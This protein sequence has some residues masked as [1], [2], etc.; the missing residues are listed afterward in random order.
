[1]SLY[2]LLEFIEEVSRKFEGSTWHIEYL[3]L[4][5]ELYKMSTTGSSVQSPGTNPGQKMAIANPLQ[6]DTFDPGRQPLGRWL[7][8]LEGTFR[9]FQIREEADQVAYLLH[10]VVV[11]VFGILCDQLDPVDPYT[12]SY[13]QYVNNKIKRVLRAGALEI[14]EIYIYRKRM[15]RPEESAQE[16]MAALQKLSLHCKFGEYL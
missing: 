12:Q 7:Q 8:R 11:E 1:M 3:E 2:F 5:R 14:A 9:V 4:R 10:F 13:I 15:Q 16:Y 6:V